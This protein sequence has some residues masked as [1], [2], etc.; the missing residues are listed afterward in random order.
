MKKRLIEF[1]AYLGIGQLAFEEKVGLSRGYVN[2]VVDSIRTDTVNKIISVYPE[3]SRTWLLTGEGEMI[4]GAQRAS[5][6]DVKEN[7][8]FVIGNARGSNN[9]YTNNPGCCLGE[10]EVYKKQ[11]DRVHLAIDI[12][13]E[14]LKRFH[15]ESAQKTAYIEKMVSAS[16]HRNE[17]QMKRI[18]ELIQIIIDQNRAIMK[19]DESIQE[20]ADKLFALL[21][22]KL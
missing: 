13:C 18:D 4:K 1:L 20:R 9:T 6:G 5:F 19:Q 22:K 16:F 17:A 15:E 7:S 21:E 11:E 8:G 10:G 3:L 12:L 2:K 14:E